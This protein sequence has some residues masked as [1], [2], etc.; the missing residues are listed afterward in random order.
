MADAT[1]YAV[2]GRAIIQAGGWPAEAV[3]RV[4]LESYGKACSEAMGRGREMPD[5]NAYITPTGAAPAA[6]QTRQAAA[7]TDH[8]ADVYIRP[9]NARE[10]I[11]LEKEGIIS[12]GQAR[13]Y[14][15]LKPHWWA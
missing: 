10:I 13:V 15:G 11:E 9:R 2:F 6:V 1:N 4:N 8:I 5:P 3:A 7:P 12:K 14:L